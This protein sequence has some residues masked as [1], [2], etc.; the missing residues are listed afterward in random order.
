MIIMHYNL[1]CRYVVY[2]EADL[3]V[4]N[5]VQESTFNTCD[6]DVHKIRRGALN[7]FFSR[8][9]IN[10][11]E[12]MIAEKVEKMCSRLQGFRQNQTPLDLR[13]LFSCFTSDIISDY[14]FPNCFDYLSTDDLAPWWR[15]S[16]A[17][18]LRNFQWL[19][20]FPGLWIVMRAIP[21]DVLK[22]VSPQV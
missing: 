16:F 3:P 9:S 10:A 6:A 19:K 1:A 5:V 13:L 7:P 20:H 4:L 2:V 21:Y 8:K 18:G 17:E 12:P 15:N 22:K 11:L 14:C